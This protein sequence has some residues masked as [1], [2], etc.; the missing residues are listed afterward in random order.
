MQPVDPWPRAGPEGWRWV[1]YVNLPIGLVA[2]APAA[3]LVPAALRA[4][5]RGV[6]LDL[7]GRCCSAP[8][9]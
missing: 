5:W 9:C 6:H 7:V 8:A 1:F 4:G 2:L 3:R